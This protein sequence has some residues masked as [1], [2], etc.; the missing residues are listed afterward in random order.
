MDAFKEERRRHLRKPLNLA[1]RM[2]IM[3]PEE[4][5][6]PTLQIGYAKNMSP[7]GMLVH[8]AEFPHS[9]Y[10]KL[11]QKPR[12]GRI[13]IENAEQQQKIDITGTVVWVDYQR[14]DR[15]QDTAPCFLG[16]QFDQQGNPGL[17]EYREF[18]NQLIDAEMKAEKQ[19]KV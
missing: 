2:R 12:Y 14:T 11:I 6:T 3:I 17:S 19:K 15:S 5:F 13:T 16:V 18:L 9:L 7:N 1:L 8:I 4:T 10:A